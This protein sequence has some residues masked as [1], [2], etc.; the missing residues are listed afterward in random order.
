MGVC[1]WLYLPYGPQRLL[2]SRNN[3]RSSSRTLTQVSPEHLPR[4]TPG[5]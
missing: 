5:P 2:Q 1:R 3:R 4:S